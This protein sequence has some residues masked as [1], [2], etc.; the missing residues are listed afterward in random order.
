MKMTK[1][2]SN[3]AKY[4]GISTVAT[5]VFIA[6]IVLFNVLLS[7]LESTFP[8]MTID[9]TEDRIYSL[10]D[11]LKETV[12]GIEVP[13]TITICEDEEAVRADT[14]L[15]NFGLHYSQVGVIVEKIRERNPLVSVQYVD[16]DR[17]PLFSSG[18]RYQSLTLSEG[19]VIVETDYRAVALATVDLYDREFDYTTYGYR[20][21]MQV[22]SALNTAILQASVSE[23]PLIAIAGGSHAEMLTEDALKAFSSVMEAA[24]FDLC[25]VDLLKEDIPEGTDIILIPTPAA[26]YTED[27]IR[28]LDQFLS[29]DYQNTNRSVWITAHPS[30]P[31]LPN[32]TGFMNEWGM[33]PEQKMVLETNS[34]RLVYPDASFLVSDLS[35]DFEPAKGYTYNLF[36]TP[37]SRPVDLL[38][39]ASNGIAVYALS[40]TA[41]SCY[42]V[43]SDQTTYNVKVPDQ[44]DR[45]TTAAIGIRSRFVASDY[46]RQSVV[47][48]GSSIM[49]TQSYLAN[50]TFGNAEYLVNLAKY[51]TNTTA[52]KY[53]APTVRTEAYRQDITMSE[54]AGKVFGLGVFTI[55]IPACI[56]L[57]GIAVFL[58]RRYL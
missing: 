37:Q 35:P 36:A 14:L 9:M 47:V 24:S 15:S 51:V 44:L 43:D 57:A 19:S 20:Y 1:L 50:A 40:A 3:K 7:A 29:E 6:M 54:R 52:S 2:L 56:L 21:Y 27:E 10:S 5:I 58:K 34:G 23:I 31:E 39:D 38:F 16:L 30:Q 45:Y 18:E 4:G 28:K 32:L 25:T 42:T 55:G 46:Y 11:E 41:G 13:L 33:D 26:D 17:N 53:V 48:F 12:D 8:S 22:D 49:F